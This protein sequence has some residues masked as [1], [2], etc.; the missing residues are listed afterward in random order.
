MITYKNK[1]IKILPKSELPTVL[2]KHNQ[3]DIS[4]PFHEY[5]NDLMEHLCSF[6]D[7]ME[8]HDPKNEYDTVYSFYHNNEW[9]VIVFDSNVQ[10]NRTYLV[11]SDYLNRHLENK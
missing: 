2:E 8:K 4:V 9:G 7:D 3:S 11:I 6:V 10:Q 5:N 1:K